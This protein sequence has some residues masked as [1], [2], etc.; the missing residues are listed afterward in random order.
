MTSLVGTVVDNRYSVIRL[1]GAGGMGAVYEVEH[2]LIDRRFAL[3]TL[4]PEMA[5]NTEAV[6]R[7]HKEARAAGRI[8][9]EHIVEVS[10]MGHLPSGT[11]YMILELLEGR[12]LGKE[13]TATGPLPVPRVVHITRQVCNALA[14]AHRKDIVHRDLK[15]DNV[16]LLQNRPQ[17]DFVKL[18]DFGISKIRDTLHGI[19]EPLTRTG[20]AL[21]TPH[22]M[23]PEQLEGSANVDARTDV[24][25]MGVVL[26]QVLTG[27]VPYDAPSFPGLVIKIMQEPIP[28]VRALQ[29]HV[30][31]SLDLVIRRA[32]AKERARR[33]DTIEELAAALEPHA[34]A[35]GSDA[36]PS[37]PAA[38]VT[39]PT[40]RILQSVVPA[41]RPW[42]IGAAI[43]AVL[44][45]VAVAT[46]MIVL[47]S[48]GETPSRPGVQ[49]PA[50][51]TSATPVA[52]PRAVPSSPRPPLTAVRETPRSDPPPALP[53]GRGTPTTTAA[54]VDPAGHDGPMR[55]GPQ[56][57]KSS[58]WLRSGTAS[59]GTAASPPQ[60]AAPPPPAEP[61]LRAITLRSAV[62]AR[63]T[64]TLTCGGATHTQV[65]QA[66]GTAAMRVP[67][68]DCTVRCEGAGGPSCPARLESGA[69]SIAVE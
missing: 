60:V 59:N 21:G 37:A 49:A 4:H 57:T 42:R 20:A 50:T 67:A 68:G 47:A 10:D 27:Q 62:R 30:P 48:A 11:P 16:F 66:N 44:G 35:H 53:Q 69:D 18:L 14:A 6:M 43:A 28:S 45:L 46:T 36:G 29:P 63:V 25:A 38:V 39:G 12:D 56:Q 41:A 31:E 7:F 2:R 64:V 5:K 8:G 1:I 33:F 23:A 34:E 51:R 3:K 13:L 9:N 58:R 61:Q 24:Y 65:V 54:A 15:P 32:M 19:G 22:Y 52:P 26:Y 55:A 40:T 17:K